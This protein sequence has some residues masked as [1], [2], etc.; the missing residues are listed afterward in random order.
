MIPQSKGMS[1][2]LRYSLSC[3]KCFLIVILEKEALFYSEFA[4]GKT[5]KVIS[6]G[7]RWI[8][9]KLKDIKKRKEEC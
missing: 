3:C 1:A 2:A 9:K 8:K 6:G 7:I 5:H 4:P